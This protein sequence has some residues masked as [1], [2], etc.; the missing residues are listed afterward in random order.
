G[1][2]PSTLEALKTLEEL[3]AMIEGTPSALREALAVCR[4]LDAE[5][6]ESREPAELEDALL[7]RLA[8][9]TRS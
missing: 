4:A 8:A 6:A 1:G 7:Q 2:K 5:S 9:R 3:R